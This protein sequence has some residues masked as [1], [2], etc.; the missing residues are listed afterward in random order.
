MIYLIFKIINPSK[1]IGVYNL[2]CEIKIA[3]LDKLVGNLK[4]LLG[5]I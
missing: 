2:K 3:T 1:R 4:D 5:D